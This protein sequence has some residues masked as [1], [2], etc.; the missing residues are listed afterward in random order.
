MNTKTAF[1]LDLPQRPDA[2][3]GDA[4]RHRHRR[5]PDRRDRAAARLRGGGNRCR[6]QARPAR[7]RRYPYPPRQGLPARPLRARP[8]QRRRGHR[9]GRRH[10]ARLHGGGRLRARRAGDRARDRARHDADAHPC[11]DRPAHRLAQLRGD[12]GAEAR[13]RLGDRSLDLRVSA[14]RPDQ[15]SRRRGT[16]GRGLARRRRSDRR[17]S[18]HGHRP[19]RASGKDFRSRAGSSTSM[20]TCISTS[21][22]IRPGGISTRSAG[23]PSG[24]ITRA[25]SRSATPP[26]CRRC[27]R[28]G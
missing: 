23:R 19:E 24:A 11:R 9:R 25:A 18:L 22:S 10:E 14:G 21:I 1:D 4:G 13:L 5:R 12:Q 17:L 6:R 8:W 15:R 28:T 16:A 2:S 7:L 27:R 26:N 20:S 3:L